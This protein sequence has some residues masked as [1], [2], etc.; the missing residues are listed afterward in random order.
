MP[1]QTFL[2]LYTHPAKMAELRFG[3][4]FEIPS[5]ETKMKI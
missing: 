3:T 5:V 2:L 4:Y 1:T